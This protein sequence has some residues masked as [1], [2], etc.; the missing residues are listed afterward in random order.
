MIGISRNKY[1]QWHYRKGKENLHNSFI[2]KKNWTLPEEKQAVI[3]YVEDNYPLNSIFLKQGYRRITYEMLDKDIAALRPS[4]VYRILKEAGLLNR[5][6]TKKS[7][8]K[9]KGFIQ[10]EKPHQEWHTD[11]KYVNHRGT[12]LFLITVMDGYSRYILHHELRTH[13]TE[14]DVE[15]T[16][17][18]A[19]EKY[20]LENPRLISD[21]GPQYKSKDFEK[22]LKEI[23]LQHIKTSVGYPQSN[24][25]MERFYRTIAEECLSTKSMIN[26]EEARKII[27]DYID[28]YNKNRLHSSLYYLTPDD[29]LNGRVDERIKEREEKI[30]TAIAKRIAYRTRDNA[31]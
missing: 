25:K 30:R 14:Y 23:G 12:Y 28:Y 1:Y 20:S 21:N 29:F 22:Y 7:S 16:I 17:Q 19:R 3:N 31:A 27:S 26:I 5:W 11:I 6:S 13:M 4:V 24:G 15:I 2:P 18:K 10:P 8:M 9:G